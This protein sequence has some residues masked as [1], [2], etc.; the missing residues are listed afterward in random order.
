MRLLAQK[1]RVL[2]VDDH[3]VVRAGVHQ[4]LESQSEVVVVGEAAS[5]PEALAQAA[6]L[7]P[8]VILMD[9]AMPG[10][11]GLEAA[12]LLREQCPDVKVLILTMHED[13]GYFFHALRAGA[14]G[15]ILKEASPA[16]LVSAIRVVCGGG[17]YFHPS[18]ARRLLDDYLSLSETGGSRE[19]PV[20]TLTEREQE[21]LRLTA[22]GR[23]SR[24]IAEL[25]Y[26]SPRTVERHRTN[27]MTKLNLHNRASLIR[28]AVSRGLIT[29][30]PD[31]EENGSN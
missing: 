12:G 1:I 17:V 22:A 24:Q 31:S 15:Y 13:D 19:T 5:G 4:L 21:V 29:P 10:M 3:A 11:T 2:T 30:D 9:I 18:M 28:Y 25:L 14:A 6:T 7:K 20:E 27:I 8:D 16:E 23:T 26:L